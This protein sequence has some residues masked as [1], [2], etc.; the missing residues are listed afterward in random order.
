[1]FGECFV[2]LLSATYDANYLH[3]LRDISKREAT[4]S[5]ESV[6]PLLEGNHDQGKAPKIISATVRPDGLP[7]ITV[8]TGTFVF[9]MGMK[10]WMH[11]TMFD[12][13]D[14]KSQQFERNESGF[15]IPAISITGK[16]NPRQLLPHIEVGGC[17]DFVVCPV[18]YCVSEWSCWFACYK[19][20]RCI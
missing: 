6:T 8:A 11:I 20:T 2:P 15:K 9:H 10:V 12:I 16:L 14:Q 3:T 17:F 5:N 13:D 19:V 7:V 1:M 4:L 18:P